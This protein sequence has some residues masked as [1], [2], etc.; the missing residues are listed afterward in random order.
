MH[1]NHKRTPPAWK[2]SPLAGL[3]CALHCPLSCIIFKW[4]CSP[5]VIDEEEYGLV[6]SC[7][8]AKNSY[9]ELLAQR[10]VQCYCVFVC[11]SL[12]DHLQTLHS[13][14]SYLK[15]LTEAAKLALCN[16]FLENYRAKYGA[17]TND[18]ESTPGN[19]CC[20]FSFLVGA[21]VQ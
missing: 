5:S 4:C 11:V 13:E 10:Q 20:C 18:S 9:K 2:V 17:A 21:V 8:Q 19:P 6:T 15:G 3:H 14:T 1:E 12:I 16:K 7:K